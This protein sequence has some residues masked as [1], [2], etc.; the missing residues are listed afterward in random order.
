ML[1]VL[2][3]PWRVRALALPLVA[4]AAAAGARPAG[5]WPFD[6]L[7]LD[8]G[9]GT[10]VLVRTRDHLLVFDTGPQYSRDSDAGQRVL[11]PLL[12]APRRAR[13]DRW[14]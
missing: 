1:L 3:L 12:R 14:C 11:L 9:Q 6:L 7:A 4:A 8:V 5:G 10:A 13:I 2:P